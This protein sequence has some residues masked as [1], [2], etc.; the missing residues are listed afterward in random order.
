M[1]GSRQDIKSIMN[2]G[3]FIMIIKNGKTAEKGE[4]G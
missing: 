2:E 4:L 3:E 1:S